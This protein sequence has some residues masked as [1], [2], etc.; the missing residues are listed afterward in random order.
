[1]DEI[2]SCQVDH[3]ERL[4]DLPAHYGPF[5][6]MVVDAAV[7]DAAITD[8]ERQKLADLTVEVVNTIA[9]ELTPNFWRPN[10]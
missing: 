2:R 1:M 10:R 9:A 7:G 3:D 5:L 8:I 6:R 4:P